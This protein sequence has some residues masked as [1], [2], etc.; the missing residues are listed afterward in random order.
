[1]QGDIFPENMIAE[2]IYST[3]TLLNIA[4][5]IY[6]IKSELFKYRVN[7]DGSIT[8][9]VDRHNQ[10]IIHALNLLNRSSNISDSILLYVNLLI[11]R[12]LYLQGAKIDT[13]KY[14]DKTAK[15]KYNSQ[16]G[17]IILR[18]ELFLVYKYITNRK[19]IY[20]NLM[21]KTREFVSYISLRL[22]N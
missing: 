16:G 7:R 3:P 4:S 2:D 21:K 10:A 13:I 20:L 1:M 6:Y 17:N 9:N 11:I 15:L 19:Y 22:K 14:L 18:L 8:S 5:S 12:H